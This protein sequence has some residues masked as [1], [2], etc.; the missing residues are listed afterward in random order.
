MDVKTRRWCFSCE[1]ENQKWW[2]GLGWLHHTTENYNTAMHHISEKQNV[3]SATP[4][5]IAPS[6][7]SAYHTFIDIDCIRTLNL[8]RDLQ[9]SMYCFVD[10]L[11][12]SFLLWPYQPSSLHNLRRRSST[13]DLGDNR[14]CIWIYR[15]KNG[16]GKEVDQM[17]NRGSWSQEFG[18]DF[19]FEF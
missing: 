11:I 18:V 5:K 2:F 16:K 17:G 6:N 8:K 10:L 14:G 15:G 4:L 3:N 12:N 19:G 7:Y 13:S 9:S 1:Q